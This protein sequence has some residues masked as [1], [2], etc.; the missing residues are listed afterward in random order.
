M[1]NHVLYPASTP[2]HTFTIPFASSNI[3]KVL[4]SYKQR[5][6]VVLAKEVTTFTNTENENECVLAIE[7]TQEETLQFVNN[8][9]INVQLN[10]FTTDDK[11]L[12]SDPI[13]IAAGDQYERRVIT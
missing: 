5:G 8:T 4:V 12:T 1:V 3:E 6:S 13:Q 2:T 9:D 10:V 7:L 11:R